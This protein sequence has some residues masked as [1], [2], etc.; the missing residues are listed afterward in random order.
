MQQEYKKHTYVPTV[1]QA[2]ARNLSATGR[3]KKQA[4]SML[5]DACMVVVSLWA[6]YALRFGSFD[7]DIAHLVYHFAFLTPLTVLM[8]TGLGIYRWVVR[9]ST[10]GLYLQVLK[11]AFASSAT[12]LL[13]MYLLPGD[14]VQP[15]SAFLIYG[16][17]LAAPC[18]ILTVR[19]YP[20]PF[21]ALDM[22]A[23]SWPVS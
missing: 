5:L 3:G 14:G 19:A 20:L 17:V 12:L 16:L 2:I 18:S 21:L 7:V 6:A 9:T 23:L 10:F 13:L 1:I 22:R 15:R 8:F 11:G 4:I